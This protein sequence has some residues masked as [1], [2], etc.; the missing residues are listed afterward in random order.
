MI[1]NAYPYCMYACI[2]ICAALVGKNGFCWVNYESIDQI[3]A[4][5][6]GHVVICMIH[7]A[8]YLAM[9]YFNFVHI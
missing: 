1:I 3:N 5:R 9:H 6:T 7:I 2:C 8:S 4:S